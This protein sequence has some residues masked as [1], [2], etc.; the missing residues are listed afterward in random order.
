MLDRIEIWGFKSTPWTLLCSSNYSWTMLAVWQGAL[1]CWKRP[2]PSGHTVAVK[3]CTWVCN[4]VWVGGKDPRFPSG[5]LAR[6]SHCL[7][8]LAFSTVQPS[9]PQVNAETHPATHMSKKA[10]FIRPGH[11]PPW[12]SSGAHM[13]IVGTF[14]T[15]VSTGP[16]VCGYE[17]SCDALKPVTGS[18]SLDHFW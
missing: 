4:N 3:G 14:G 10:W 7:R 12:S 18:P 13:A 9:L 6:A 15:G 17:A 1:S 16:L 8:Q 2:L 11:L 5:T